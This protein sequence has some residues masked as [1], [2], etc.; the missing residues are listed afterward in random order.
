MYVFIFAEN[1]KRPSADA[2]HDLGVGTM[3]N[4]HCIFLSYHHPWAVGV[5]FGA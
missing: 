1:H 3:M 4:W 2:V 5:L